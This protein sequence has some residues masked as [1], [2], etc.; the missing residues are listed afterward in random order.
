MSEIMKYNNNKFTRSAKPTDGRS[1]VQL[2][3][4]LPFEEVSVEWLM[5]LASHYNHH[6]YCLC[7]QFRMTTA[8]N[9]F[10]CAVQ[11]RNTLILVYT[12][13]SA[14]CTHTHL[15]N[16]IINLILVPLKKVH[17]QSQA[18][19]TQHIQIQK[20]AKSEWRK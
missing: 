12:L 4:A 14:Q 6:Y 9:P 1:V 5:M 19:S 3:N 16:E 11:L 20:W 15:S 7:V 8:N 18:Q 2:R 10:V 17:P 13:L